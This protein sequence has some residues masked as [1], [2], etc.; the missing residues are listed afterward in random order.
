MSTSSRRPEGHRSG[1]CARCCAVTSARCFPSSSDTGAR[2]IGSGRPRPTW[3]SRR[4]TPRRRT[5]SD[6][7][8]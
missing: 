8:A 2:S 6:D 3:P 5:R 1:T 7:P 4:P